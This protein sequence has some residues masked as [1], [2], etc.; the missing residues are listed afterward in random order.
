[1]RVLARQLEAQRPALTHISNAQLLEHIMT[2]P[3]TRLPSCDLR[4]LKLT[5]F[6]F[7]DHSQMP[8][9]IFSGMDLRGVTLRKCS[10]RGARLDRC[11]LEDASFVECDL[12]E[13]HL[14]HSVCDGVNLT[15]STLDC[16]RASFVSF[17]RATLDRASFASAT[18]KGASFVDATVHN[19]NFT[20]AML[21]SSICSASDM[22]GSRFGGAALDN[23]LFHQTLLDGCQFSDT[24]ALVGA[25]FFHASLSLATLPLDLTT[26]KRWSASSFV[27][28]CLRE[29]NCQGCNFDDAD[30]T[31]ADLT[32]ARLG[33][34]TL[35]G[36]VFT[37]AVLER[38][39]LP[40]GD[41]L[42]KAVAWTGAVL[43]ECDLSRVSLAECDMSHADF[44]NAR[45]SNIDDAC[46]CNIE[47]TTFAYA[48][49][50]NARMPLSL[51]PAASWVHA[52][53][54]HVDLSS[55]DLAHC[56]LAGAHLQCANLFNANI[57]ATDF[58]DANVSQAILPLDL[59]P[60]QSWLRATF[61]K[62]D[63]TGRFLNAI[64]FSHASFT[65][66]TLT[67]ALVDQATFFQARFDTAILPMDM[68]AA[69][70]WQ[71]ASL[72]ATVLIGRN[73]SHCNLIGADLSDAD[74]TYAILTDCC[75]R[76]ACLDGVRPPYAVPCVWCKRNGVHHKYALDTL[77]A[78]GTPRHVVHGCLYGACEKHKGNTFFGYSRVLE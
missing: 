70:T 23:V 7:G 44:S 33:E 46:T 22:V 5:Y 53:L 1:M 15:D 26:A 66:A 18:L 39:L 21:V 62:C 17:K 59:S 31:G 36:A 3:I 41:A 20:D 50:C 54:A 60:A 77:K 29:R 35:T 40:S 51:A 11:R 27:G 2:C 45:F 34:C 69:K 76:D 52:Q 55:R 78:S 6:R 68:S 4:A 8:L 24:T 56:A 58:T 75:M 16:A 38:A 12:R 65:G 71:G 64:D 10:L 43:R 28:T 73:L 9:C 48:I 67:L 63:L 30:F 47:R 74:L 37:N 19:A 61:D 14:E 13:V 49:F 42:A 72:R 32:E 57:T 25:D